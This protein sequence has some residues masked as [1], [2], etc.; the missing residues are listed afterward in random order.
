MLKSSIK[1]SIH[2]EDINLNNRHLIKSSQCL[3]EIYRQIHKHAQ[4]RGTS[5]FFTVKGQTKDSKF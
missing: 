5:M 3:Q 1:N 4:S 2:Q